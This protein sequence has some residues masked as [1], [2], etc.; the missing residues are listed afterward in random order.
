MARTAGLQWV[1][2]AQVLVNLFRQCFGDWSRVHVHSIGTGFLL[3]V[4]TMRRLV[5]SINR[6][7]VD[8]QPV[9]CLSKLSL[10]SFFVT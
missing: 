7:V 9:Y 4:D 10:V 3:L 1:Y 6:M 2:V 8:M 5:T